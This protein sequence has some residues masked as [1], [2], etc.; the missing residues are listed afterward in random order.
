[1]FKNINIILLMQGLL[2]MAPISLSAQNPS[3]KEASTIIKGFAEWQAARIE[4]IILD[5]GLRSLANDERIEKYFVTTAS[6][7][8][9]YQTLSAKDMLPLIADSIDSDVEVMSRILD[10]CIP[11]NVL[12]WISDVDDKAEAKEWYEGLNKGLTN[13]FDLANIDYSTNQFKADVCPSMDGSQDYFSQLK[14]MIQS[15]GEVDD[16]SEEGN[17]SEESD[18]A[19][20]R[21]VSYAELK[22]KELVAQSAL[23]VR[24]QKLDDNALSDI[25]KAAEINLGKRVEKKERNSLDSAVQE[26][27]KAESE[28]KKIVKH[29]CPKSKGKD[30]DKDKDK[31]KGKDTGPG[32]LPNKLQDLINMVAYIDKVRD[33]KLT[34]TLR[35]HYLLLSMDRFNHLSDCDYIGFSS[36][37]QVSMFFAGLSDAVKDGDTTAVAGVLESFVDYKKAY[38]DKRAPGGLLWASYHGPKYDVKLNKTELKTYNKMGFVSLDLY[39]SS[40][41]GGYVGEMASESSPDVTDIQ[42]RFFGPVGFELKLATFTKGS[43]SANY[44]PIDIG[45]Y[46]TNELINEEYTASFDDIFAPSYFLSFSLKRAPVA[47]LVGYQDKIKLTET[48]ETSGPFIGITFDL[49]IFKLY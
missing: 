19:G 48:A 49:P 9:Q 26:G 31:D 47:V 17:G 4:K 11:Y 42:T 33:K 2:I 36:L 10:Q 12:K 46:V 15:M 30:K 27:K 14:L 7:I 45:T 16:A 8:K 38:I 6:S 44:A 21:V 34:Y 39:V 28:N 1:M 3:E 29:N 37:Q 22:E 23:V 25:I 40:F 24:T 20:S 32:E 18:D 13:Y 35:I 43:L 41:Y 5:N